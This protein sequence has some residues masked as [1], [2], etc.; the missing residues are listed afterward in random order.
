MPSPS[1]P[2]VSVVMPVREEERYL[3]SSVRGILDQG[4]PGE[5]EIILVVAPSKDA[6]ATIAAQLAADNPSIRV[7]DNPGGTTPL[8]LNLGVAAASHDVIVRVDAHGE[9]GADYIATA[10]ELLERTGAANVGGVMDARGTTAFEQ[11][12]AVAYTSRLGLGSSAFHLG[13]APEGPA[14]TVF[15]G[16]FRKADLEEVGG[17]D[18]S[19]DRAQDWELNYRLRQ[20]GHQ[21]WFSPRLRVTYR[22]RSTTAALARQFFRTG[23]W[24]RQV[25]R[26]HRDSV[27]L[28]YLAAPTATAACALGVLS[29]VVGEVRGLRRRSRWRDGE[30]ASAGVLGGRGVWALGWAAPVGYLGAMVAG[31]ALMRRPMSPQVRVRLP[32]VLAVMHLSWGAGFLV[33]LPRDKG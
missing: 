24:R 23:Q 16:V 11:A 7:V 5:V 1:A 18:P 3:A 31:S 2:P 30:A 13:D 32:W 21:V 12:V 6:T 19:F 27:S 20:A 10:V 22:P 28:R 14:E 8:A 25:M 15:L 17:F 26:R 9:L 33:G 4:Y 29:G